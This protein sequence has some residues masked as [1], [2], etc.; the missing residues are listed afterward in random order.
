[1]YLKMTKKGGAGKTEKTF[2]ATDFI[3]AFIMIRRC[4]YFDKSQ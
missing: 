3:E 4:F 2:Q 1:M